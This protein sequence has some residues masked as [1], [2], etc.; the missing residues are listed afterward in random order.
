[1]NEGLNLL[2]LN[3]QLHVMDSRYLPSTPDRFPLV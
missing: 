2:P 3:F 1:M